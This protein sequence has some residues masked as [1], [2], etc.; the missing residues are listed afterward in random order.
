MLLVN[1]T[2][3]KNIDGTGN[4]ITIRKRLMYITEIGD[5]SIYPTRCIGVSSAVNLP[6][7]GF[8][9]ITDIKKYTIQKDGGNSDSM[10]VEDYG[11][12]EVE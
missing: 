6:T 1:G 2:L 11:E 10:S 4:T 8:A 5:S 3:T 12:G 7:I 9:L